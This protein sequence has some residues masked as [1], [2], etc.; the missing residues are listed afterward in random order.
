VRDSD[1]KD[2]EADPNENKD[3][4]ADLKAK[5]NAFAPRCG[6]QGAQEGS[7]ALI[8]NLQ[9]A[10]IAELGKPKPSLD[11]AKKALDKIEEML[12]A[13]AV[14]TFPV[15]AVR[16]RG[17][18][19]STRESAAIKGITELSRRSTNHSRA[20]PGRGMPYVKR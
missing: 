14:S 13:A 19:G 11:N 1:G 15:A 4:V 5:L 10:G 17:R 7:A 6:Q 18:T 9:K 3:V 2:L 12:G 8:G 16:R 20:E